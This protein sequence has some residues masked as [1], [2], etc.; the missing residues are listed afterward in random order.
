MINKKKW[1]FFVLIILTI[2]ILDVFNLTPL[3]RLVSYTLVGLS[4]IGHYFFITDLKIFPKRLRF[5][6]LVAIL[7]MLTSIFTCYIHYGQSL[8]SGF[9]ANVK[10]YH[11]GSVIL[12]VYFFR[13]YKLSPPKYISIIIKLGWILLIL[14]ALMVITNFEFI[15]ESELTGKIVSIH[16]GKV[17]KTLINLIAIF[18]FSKFLYKSNY[19][20]LLYS[21]LFFAGNH[22][23][24]IQRF[25]LLTILLI[26]G[27]GFIKNKNSKSKIKV[28]MPAIF[29]I[30]LTAIFLFN[31]T[32]GD[33]LI[34]RFYEAAKIVTE[35]DASNINDPSTAIRIFE[36][37]FALERFK[38]HPFFG[39]GFFRASEKDNV[40][41]AGIYFYPLDIGLYGVLY[42]FGILGMIIFLLQL[43]L[44]W[45][46]LKI[47]RLNQYGFFV[48]LG[49]LFFVAYSVLTGYMI[50]NYKSFYFLVCLFE[51]FNSYNFVGRDRRYDR[52]L[53]LGGGQ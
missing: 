24:E 35:E 27:V 30:V 8:V 12:F 33:S 2:L 15:N 44:I 18:W 37:D 47:K 52:H 6:Y 19:E 36:M 22:F 50:N 16:A 14:L 21:L 3:A 17:D 31:T 49:L 23:Y 7:L 9:V 46:Y 26:I 41:G 51:L 43:K 39:N 32:E 28:I 45:K 10:F 42:S 53:V 40:I 25:N 38:E 48:L 4:T 13:K 20:Y 11:T 1:V 5:W 29:A 34:N